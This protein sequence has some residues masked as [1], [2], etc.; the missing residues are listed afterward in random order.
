MPDG[1]IIVTA[2]IIPL[3][4]DVGTGSTPG[5]SLGRGG[6]YADDI[7]ESDPVTPPTDGTYQPPPDI[8]VDPAVIVTQAIQQALNRF[9][10]NRL[11][12]HVAIGNAPATTLI[13][14]NNGNF[15]SI[16]ELYSNWLNLDFRLSSR[17]FPT[18]FGGQ[19]EGKGPWQSS[20]SPATLTGYDA[21]SHGSIYLALHELAH[22]TFA[23]TDFLTEQ[24]G[25]YRARGGLDANWASSPEFI[26]T[27]KYANDIARDLAVALELPVM[28]NPTHGY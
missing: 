5:G 24:Y 4:W 28:A 10:M 3:T 27:E 1:E 6:F 26:L 17:T 19:V 13:T 20:F 2:R 8:I 25:I 18:G 14:T 15:V 11:G 9:A 12:V 16:D 22:T 21:D 23:S 7:G